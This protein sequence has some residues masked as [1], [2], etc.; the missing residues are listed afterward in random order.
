MSRVRERRR[1]RLLLEEL[2]SRHLLDG[3]SSTVALVPEIDQFGDQIATVQAYGD[4]DNATLGIFD[5]GASAITFAPDDLSL[6]GLTGTSIPV[7]VAGGAE[8]GGIGGTI[9]GDVSEPGSILADGIHAMGLDFT[10]LDFFRF[11]LSGSASVPGVQALL[12][13]STGS[14][15]LPT[16]TGTPILNP[17]PT[18][19]FG[20]AASIDMQGY[21]FDLSG[22]LPELDGV[23][24]TMPDLHFVAPGTQLSEAT[25]TTAPLYIPL[26]FYG[27]DNHADPG[28]DI[29]ES[30]SPMQNDVSVVQG[31]ASVAGQHFLLDTGAQLTVISTA[32]AAS[33]GV[34]LNA[35]TTS[36]S[37]QGVA[38]SVDIPGFTISSLS[39]PTTDG[40]TLTFTSVPVYVLDVAPGVDGLLGMNLFNT[41][42][43]LLYDPNNPAGSR[44]G[45]T[46]RTDPN[47]GAGDLSGSDLALLQTLGL[48]SFAGIVSGH[49]IPGFLPAVAEQA[50]TT[51]TLSS[52]PTPSSVYGQPVSFTATVTPP[53]GAA[54]L[55]GTVTFT[56]DGKPRPAIPIAAD[57]IA[58][59]GGLTLPIGAHAIVASYSGSAP[60][61]Q[62]EPLHYAVSKAT[63][64]TTVKASRS[65]SYLNQPV[66]F[67]ATVQIAGPGKAM[68]TG[69]VTLL[70]DGIA[71]ARQPLSVRAN[72]LFTLSNLPAGSHIVTSKY[73][74]SSLVA[75]STSSDFVYVVARTALAFQAL[76]DPITAGVR[77]T[78]IVEYRD[79]LG[80]RLTSFNGF[81]T[82]AKQSGVG[83]L[84]GKSTVRASHGIATFNVVLTRPG[85]YQLKATTPGQL[86]AFSP[87][88]GVHPRS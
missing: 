53:A 15:D 39:V 70:I 73:S 40:G 12:G 76:P 85:N 48:G 49:A 58:T 77:F 52:T 50:S 38:G 84:G 13:T 2:E 3:T 44:L 66:T 20:L 36:I 9:T 5:T 8:A 43:S 46:F 27:G 71:R 26:G 35:P 78:V 68:P 18:N 60:A 16:I 22:L 74:G 79:P 61:A 29:T 19:P 81:V 11:D 59:L 80:Q 34:D 45:V 42:A 75:S 56:I 32:I 17:S 6:F 30:P 10:S 88:L 65:G 1:T 87:S 83:A 57:G 86:T 14:P 64:T 4:A 25:G 67:S 7:K 51:V 41:A 62:S 24:F 69:T 55:T 28:N 21:S 33:L 23:S 72:A 47:R 37:V 31:T 63:S 82:L 54:T